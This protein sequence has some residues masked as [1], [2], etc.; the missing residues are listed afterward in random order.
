MA[1]KKLDPTKVW[2][3]KVSNLL[4]GKKVQ[5]VRYLTDEEVSGLGW[6][7]K[8]IVLI[9]E[10]GTCVFPSADDEGNDAGALFTTNES[11][12]AIPVL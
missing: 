12:P 1:N 5:Q 7:S 4:V 3:D 9:F 10:D 8:A 2:A 11:L 6:F